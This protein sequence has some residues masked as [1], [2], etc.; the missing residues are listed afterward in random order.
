MALEE[1]KRRK[2]LD[3]EEAAMAKNARITQAWVESGGDLAKF[4]EIVGAVDADIAI[5]AQTAAQQKATADRAAA[6]DQRKL[7]ETQF[8]N[9]VGQARTAPELARASIYARL[10]DP[11]REHAARYDVPRARWHHGRETES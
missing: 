2:D 5:R 10:R 11:A 9:L 6:N 8:S 7:T 3:G 4:S 1:E